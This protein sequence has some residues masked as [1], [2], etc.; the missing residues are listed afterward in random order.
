M[1]FSNGYKK[2][3]LDIDRVGTIMYMH[4]KVLERMLKRKI[5]KNAFGLIGAI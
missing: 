1:N 4:E 2:P 3:G 5:D